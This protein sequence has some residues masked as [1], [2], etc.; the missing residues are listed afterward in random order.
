MNLP[1]SLEHGSSTSATSHADLHSSHHLCSK[2]NWAWQKTCITLFCIKSL[3]LIVSF[4]K[5]TS[6]SQGDKSARL[7]VTCK[8]HTQE[9]EEGG[10]QNTGAHSHPEIPSARTDTTLSKISSINQNTTWFSVLLS[11]RYPGLQFQGHAFPTHP[12]THSKLKVQHYLES[13]MQ[14]AVPQAKHMPTHK[15][16]V[17]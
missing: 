11:G 3:P 9:F 16:L 17:I 10:L 1:V 15:G 12:H 7:L 13:T 5:P 2:D 4:P 8:P 6:R 14:R